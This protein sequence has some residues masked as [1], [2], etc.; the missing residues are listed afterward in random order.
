MTTAASFV[1][2]FLDNIGA[3]YEAIDGGLRVEL[4]RKQLQLIEGVPRWSWGWAPMSE[5]LTVLY[6]TYCTKTRDE[7]PGELPFEYVGPGSFR[8][9]QFAQAAT[10]LWS[11]GR[12][13]AR[14]RQGTVD[15]WHPYLVLHFHVT[16]VGERAKREVLSVIV[17]LVIGAPDAFAGFP[18]EADLR[19]TG[20]GIA[21]RQAVVSV[22]HAHE[23]ALAFVHEQLHHGEMEWAAQR[24]AW[25][26]RQR[27]SLSAYFRRAQL[28]E[29]PQLIHAAREAR[30]DELHSLASAHV[31][32]RPA[33]ATVLYLPAGHPPPSG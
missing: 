22:G 27:K 20:D 25:V 3:R 10:R 30:L 8:W 14:P 33:A 24:E 5:E 15:E 16:F 9:R 13:F 2:Q 28:E 7:Q 11:V 17:D 32:V 18:A 26:Q 31:T 21:A 4:D 23:A 1:E 29:N 19:P 6:L 12:I